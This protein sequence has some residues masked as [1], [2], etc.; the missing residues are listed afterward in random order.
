[1]NDEIKY[2]ILSNEILIRSNMLNLGIA[3]EGYNF[4][5]IH[6]KG[7]R[8]HVLAKYCSLVEVQAFLDAWE[9]QNKR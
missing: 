8:N 9:I 1:M 6:Y 4:L 7:D 2:F 3:S 5:C